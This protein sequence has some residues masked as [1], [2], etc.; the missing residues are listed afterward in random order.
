MTRV[1]QTNKLARLNTN[2]EKGIR[3]QIY[4]NLI[5]Y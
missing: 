5:S 4:E 3:I 1:P 2:N